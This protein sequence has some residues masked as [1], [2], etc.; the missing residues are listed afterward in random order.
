M[1]DPVSQVLLVD[2]EPRNLRI[3]EGILAPLGYDL[4]RASDGQEAL[5]QVE[6]DPPDLVLLDV[7]MPGLSG[8]E[9]CRQ[10]KEGEAT[11]F[12]PVV[13]VTALS[14]RES[15]IRGIEA[16]ADDFISKPVDGQEL[17][18]RVRSLLRVKQLHDEL[19]RK[20][21]DLERANGLLTEA[22]EKA[23]AASQA[24]SEFL[25][26]MSH[27]LRTP[28]NGILG[29]AQILDRDAGLSEGQRNGV[30]IIGRSGEHLL[31]LINDILDLARVEAGK[32]ELEEAEFGLGEFLQG[33]VDAVRV[34]VEQKGLSFAYE[35]DPGLPVGV[36]GDEKRLR[37]VLLNLLGNAA[38]FTETG[39]VTF[40]VKIVDPGRAGQDQAG[41]GR[42]R[43]AVEDTGPGIAADELERIF[44]PF[45]Q[46][47]E[48]GH[49]VEGTGLGLA[50]SR[51]L[52]RLMG[53]ELEV[54]SAPGRGSVFSVVVELPEAEEWRP[55]SSGSDRRPVG[56]NGG[57]K[58]ILVMDDKFENRRVLVDVLAPLGFEVVEAVDGLDGLD[59]AA[60]E[61]PELILVDL[62]MPGLD[63]LETTRRLRQLPGF[64]RVPVIATSA[65]VFERHR[66]ESLE[67][68]CDDFLPKPVRVEELLEKAGARLGVEWIYDERQGDAERSTPEEAPLTYPP[69]EELAA[70]FA[71]AQKGE[72]VKVRAEI[73]RIEALGDQYLPFAT[74]A[75]GLAGSFAM[76]RICALLEAHLE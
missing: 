31:T 47:T 6:A 37:Q 48:S 9:V 10:L 26:N 59:K 41:E 71:L 69:P 52:V 18:V 28:L 58:K 23:D 61:R 11:R 75:R 14:E 4:R 39:G 15:R 46:L 54:D 24:K 12:I 5:E 63:G 29:Y 42:I 22:R 3:L 36:R 62:V 33:M 49:K 76:E 60:T 1:T 27:E 30:E 2:D 72:V 38:K 8:F 55:V 13:L 34:R 19:Q 57:P 45:Q 40:R 51:D 68:G 21:V 66:R 32:L 35:P 50:I 70:L 25:A 17:R 74:E 64:A 56:F 67:A 20:T 65:S 43:F 53:G 16:G 44:Q 73:D 7:M